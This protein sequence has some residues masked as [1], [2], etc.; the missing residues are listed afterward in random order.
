ME[1]QGDE[2][3]IHQCEL[4]DVDYFRG[5]KW[6]CPV[7]HSEW[8]HLGRMRNRRYSYEWRIRRRIELVADRDVRR[9][10]PGNSN[11]TLVH[12]IEHGAFISEQGARML[13]QAMGES[14]HYSPSW[15]ELLQRIQS[16]ASTATSGEE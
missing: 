1:S 12:P 13:W 5:T 8:W 9:V 4:P 6:F 11:C 7:C 16:L 15:G 10:A 2:T 14:P 3:L